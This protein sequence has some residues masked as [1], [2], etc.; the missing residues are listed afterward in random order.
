MQTEVIRELS[1]AYPD[2]VKA[3]EISLPT[4]LNLINAETGEQFIVFIDEWDC[5][6]IEDKN[7]KELQK[8]YIGLN[9]DG[10]KDGIIAMLAG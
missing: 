10:L 7:N 9:M 8:D 2:I 5:I 6:F 4:V 1:I 3:D